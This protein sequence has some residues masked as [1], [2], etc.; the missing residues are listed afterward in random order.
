[1]GGHEEETNLVAES[2]GTKLTKMSIMI[3]SQRRPTLWPRLSMDGDSWST[4]S[5]AI[6]KTIIRRPEAP[7]IPRPLELSRWL[8]RI[9]RIQESLI[10]EEVLNLMDSGFDLLKTG[11]NFGH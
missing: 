5:P 9:I 1:M 6:Y 2:L 11:L 7:T 10:L 3:Q 8:A 4:Q